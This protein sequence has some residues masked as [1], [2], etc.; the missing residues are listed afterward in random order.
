[1]KVPQ[2]YEFLKYL[3]WKHFTPFRYNFVSRQEL[4]PLN[5]VACSLD[6]F[7]LWEKELTSLMLNT[8]IE[9]YGKFEILWKLCFCC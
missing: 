8:H 5:G 2:L 6:V 3:P 4:V 7:L 1:M 9:G